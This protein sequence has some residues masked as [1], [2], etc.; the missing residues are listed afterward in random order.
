M[1]ILMSFYPINYVSRSKRCSFW[2]W[3]QVIVTFNRIRNYLHRLTF[4][5]IATILT[6]ENM[7]FFPVLPVNLRT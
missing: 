3:L 6:M 4:K 1:D 2:R 7:T 5:L